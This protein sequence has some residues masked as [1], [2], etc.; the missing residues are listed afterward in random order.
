[1][2]LTK[3]ILEDLF[4]ELFPGLSI[5]VRDI[6]LTPEEMAPY[7]VGQIIRVPFFTD[8]SWRVG[9]MVTT[10]RYAVLS[11]HFRDFGSIDDKNWGLVVAPRGARFKVMDIFEFAGK[12]Q[13]TLLHLPDDAR[14][15]IF[16]VLQTNYDQKLVDMSRDCMNRK[17]LLDPIPELATEEW[18][19]RCSLPL[20]TFSDNSLVPIEDNETELN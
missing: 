13:I 14:W 6:N 4:N 18:L 10:H 17:C 16:K 5:L 9:G 2:E 11:N 19:E 20:G 7:K 1:M 3:E 8:A 12:T 15:E